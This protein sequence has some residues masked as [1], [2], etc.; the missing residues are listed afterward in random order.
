MSNKPADEINENGTGFIKNVAIDTVIFG[1]HD[2]L[3]RVLLSAYKNTNYFALPGGFIREKENLHDAARRVASERT[4]LDDIYLEQFYVFG[5]YSRYDPQPF[6][7]IMEANG[8]RPSE[9]HWLLQRFISIGYYALVDFTR[10][11]PTPAAIFDSCN[12]YDL[13]NMPE[14]IQ[15]HSKIITKAL[16]VLRANLDHKVVG[17]NLLPESFTMGELQKLYETILS[18]KL[19]RPAFQ[20]KMLS[21]C[22]LER[23][24]KKYSGGAHKAPYL[25]RFVTGE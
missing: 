7:V 17:Y 16:E 23:V 1:F 19:L 14:L 6:K 11:T 15:D 4:G 9:S 24:A 3:L 5:D 8:N 20:R 10:A 12:W 2:N 18:K 25:Y 21:L 22:I 13:N